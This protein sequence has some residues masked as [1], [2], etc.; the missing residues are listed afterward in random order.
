M[1]VLYSPVIS[2]TPSTPM[3]NWAKNDAGQRRRDRGLAGFQA[4]GLVGGDGRDQ[5]AE[6]DHEHDG[7]QQGV[8]GGPQRT[9]LRPLR[10][11][12]PRPGDPQPVRG[13]R[14]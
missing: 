8:D 12:D 13:G 10:P 7:D 14:G 9:E 1:P 6:A 2:S 4:A 5:G 3:A 11:H